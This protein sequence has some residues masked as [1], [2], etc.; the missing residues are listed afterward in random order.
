MKK[1]K[2]SVDRFLTIVHLFNAIIPLNDL[3]ASAVQAFSFLEVVFMFLYIWWGNLDKM[4]ARC[5]SFI[6][7]KTTQT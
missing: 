5:K 7:T 3:E 2:K 4:S 6:L 1:K